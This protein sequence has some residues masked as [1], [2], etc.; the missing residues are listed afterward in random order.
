MIEGGIAWIFVLDTPRESSSSI[1]MTP[2]VIAFSTVSRL[3][4]E[5]LIRRATL[6]DR[7]ILVR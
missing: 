5:G 1:D 6:T 2:S 4:V 7:L 3:S